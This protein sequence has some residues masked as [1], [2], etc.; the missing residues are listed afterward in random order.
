MSNKKSRYAE[1][2]E[3]N[4]QM[5]GPGCCAHTVTVAQ[6]EAA[7]EAARRRGHFNSPAI[8]PRHLGLDADI[9]AALSKAR[10]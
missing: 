5:Y 8:T 1:K 9:R 2:R 3:R 7:K 6:I 4:E 10:V